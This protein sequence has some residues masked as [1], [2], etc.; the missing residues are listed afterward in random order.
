MNATKYNKNVAITQSRRV[1]NCDW[2]PRDFE[3]NLE[4]DSEVRRNWDSR[5]KVNICAEKSRQKCD[6]KAQSRRLQLLKWKMTDCKR[7]LGS[8]IQVVWK[9]VQGMAGCQ[10]L[11]G[12]CLPDAYRLSGSWPLE[13]VA[14]SE[15]G[16]P[17]CWG[18]MYGIKPAR[19]N[20]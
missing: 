15:T 3:Q 13:N 6:N 19:S 5:E 1:W 12:S 17:W 10:W 2:Q 20:R 14:R 8:R 7:L 16:G 9:K 4:L 18:R 11:S